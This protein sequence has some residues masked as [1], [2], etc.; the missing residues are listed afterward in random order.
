M[1]K[2][3]IPVDQL[4]SSYLCVGHRGFPVSFPENSLVGIMAAI[5]VGADGVEFDVQ[6]SKDGVAVVC[7][8]ISLERTSKE[9]VNIGDLT[10]KELSALSCHEPD[11]FGDAHFP[12]PVSSLSEVCHEIAQLPELS[13]RKLQVFIEAKGESIDKFGRAY[14][15]KKIL[16]DSHSIAQ[17]R[18]LIS[19]DYDILA[20][21]RRETRM[22]IGWVLSSYDDQSK[23]H[24]EI[25]EPDFLICN[26][27]KMPTKNALWEGRWDWFAYDISDVA[28]AKKWFDR[29][30]EYIESWD[31]EALC[32]EL[33]S[34]KRKV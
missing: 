4:R 21:A 25:L 6:L 10:F 19:F 3:N 8:D 7:H 24:A 22:V 23:M 31:V 13:D 14:M 11:R 34:A 33:H 32:S 26:Y 18:V 20:L 27:K 12:C 17:S 15:L 29:G 9:K 28:L 2:N 1:T 5:A 30:V 16:T